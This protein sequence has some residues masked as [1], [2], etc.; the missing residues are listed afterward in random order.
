MQDKNIDC[1]LIYSQMEV[2]ADEKR[3]RT[4]SKGVRGTSLA[5]VNHSRPPLRVTF[6]LQNLFARFILTLA[7]TQPFW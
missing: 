1:L 4:R 2:D 6:I 7:F 3:H 5:S